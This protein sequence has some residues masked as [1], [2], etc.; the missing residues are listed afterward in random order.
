[1]DVLVILHLGNQQNGAIG[2]LDVQL[3]RENCAARL[4]DALIRHTKNTRTKRV[5]SKGWHAAIP[6]THNAKKYIQKKKHKGILKLRVRCG[7]CL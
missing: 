2:P 1:L 6:P 5:N 7:I 4:G 3:R